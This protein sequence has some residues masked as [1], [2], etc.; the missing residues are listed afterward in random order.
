MGQ[1]LNNSWLKCVITGSGMSSSLLTVLISTSG[2]K[3]LV[4]FSLSMT[5][6]S[7]PSQ[8]K[9][10]L[11]WWIFLASSRHDWVFSARNLSFWLLWAFLTVNN[12]LSVKS[13]LSTPRVLSLSSRA[14]FLASFFL[15]EVVRLWTFWCFNEAKLLLATHLRILFFTQ[16]PSWISVNSGTDDFLELGSPDLP[17]VFCFSHNFLQWS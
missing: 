11:V 16:Q 7:K 3:K 15:F 13:T 4:K 10:F 6:L 5:L 12:F 1:L 17:R 9:G 2:I 8:S 14:Q